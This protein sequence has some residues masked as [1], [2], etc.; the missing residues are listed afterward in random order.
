MTSLRDILY[1]NITTDIRQAYLENFLRNDTNKLVWTVDVFLKNQAQGCSFEWCEPCKEIYTNN[2]QGG[3]TRNSEKVITDLL[4]I[5]NTYNSV[6]IW[7][8][9]DFEIIND[10]DFIFFRNTAKVK[11]KNNDW[12]IREF[13]SISKVY[14]DHRNSKIIYMTDSKWKK[15]LYDIEKNRDYICW[16][17]ESF[18]WIWDHLYQMQVFWYH[19][20]NFNNDGLFR[21]VPNNDRESEWE[22]YKNNKQSKVYKFKDWKL[23]EWIYKDSNVIEV[24]EYKWYV[25]KHSIND[26]NFLWLNLTNRSLSSDLFDRVELEPIM[27]INT[28]EEI[29][30][31]NGQ[32]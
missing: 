1:G 5:I 26:H 21:F 23:M 32:G 10:T 13:D 2:K 24:K 27:S 9:H 15:K 22:I 12:N 28:K 25:R 31:P 3:Y 6:A 18:Q 29:L 7:D 30:E 20:F 8:D 16:F 17:Y 19:Q 4:E 11:I 14:K